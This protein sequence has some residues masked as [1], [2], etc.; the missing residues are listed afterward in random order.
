MKEQTESKKRT[1]G[2]EADGKGRM[3]WNYRPKGRWS[4][5]PCPICGGKARWG[6][7][8][9]GNAGP[10]GPFVYCENHGECYTFEVARKTEKEVAEAWNKRTAKGG[11]TPVCKVR[12]EASGEVLWTTQGLALRW[13]VNKAFLR[14]MVKNGL[15]RPSAGNA[16]QFLFT[17]ADAARFMDNAEGV[18]AWIDYI[19]R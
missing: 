8:G 6:F 5:Q 16:R 2:T 10:K 11:G 3:N 15:L 18:E 14:R 1:D 9:I 19:A 4:L 13:G 7:H 12:D 17:E